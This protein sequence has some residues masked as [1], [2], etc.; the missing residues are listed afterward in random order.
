MHYLVGNA[1]S[2]NVFLC[3]CEEIVA[4]NVIRV[5]VG[6]DH[7]ADVTGG[8]GGCLHQGLQFHYTAILI[9]ESIFVVPE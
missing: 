2:H 6:A 8:E 7:V 4:A 1:L 5:P 9:D 3:I